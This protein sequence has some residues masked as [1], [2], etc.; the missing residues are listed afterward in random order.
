MHAVERRGVEGSNAVVAAEGRVARARQTL[1]TAEQHYQSL[2]KQGVAQNPRDIAAADALRS[3]HWRV[4]DAVH[5]VAVAQKNLSSPAVTAGV[6]KTQNALAKLDATERGFLGTIHQVADTFK[7]V[8]R[9]A[10]DAVFSGMDRAI[11]ALLPSFKLIGPAMAGLGK[12][13]GGSF[14][15]IGRE[16]A[17]PA[18]TRFF[19]AMTHGAAV[20]VR[21]MTPGFLALARIFRDIATASLP[22]LEKGVRAVS[23]WLEKIAGQTGNAG[24]L[25]SIVGGL[26]GQFASWAKFGASVAKL[27]GTIFMGGAQQGKGLVDTL[28]RILDRWTRFLNTPKGQADMR[29]FFKDAVAVTKLLGGSLGTVVGLF[30]RLGVAATRV[31]G[32]L[33]K[34][35]QH[36]AT[37]LAGWG[38]IIGVLLLRFPALRGVFGSVLRGMGLDIGK[39]RLGERLGESIATPLNRLGRLASA[40]FRKFKTWLLGAS[41]KAGAEAGAAEGEAQATAGSGRRLA[42]FFGGKWGVFKR[43]LLG[44]SAVAGAEAGVAQGEAMTGGKGLLSGGVRSRI[45]G[46]GK[47]GALLGAFKGIGRLFGA[48][49]GVTLGA[50]LLKHVQGLTDK[51]NKMASGPATGGHKQSLYDPNPMGHSLGDKLRDGLASLSPFASGGQ[52]PGGYG[53]GDVIPAWLEPGEHVLTK[54]EVHRAGG[55]GAIHALRRALGGGGQSAGPGYAQ[56]GMVTRVDVATGAEAERKRAQRPLA[57]IRDDLASIAQAAAHAGTATHQ[58]LAARLGDARKAVAAQ[59]GRLRKTAGDDF[60]GVRKDAEAKTRRTHDDTDDRWTDLR[61]RLGHTTEKWRTDTLGV[62]DDVRKSAGKT[63]SRLADTVTGNLDDARKGAVRRVTQLRD[64]VTDRLDDARKNAGRKTKQLADTVTGNLEDARRGGSRRAGQLS[65]AVVGSAGD[66]ERGTTRHLTAIRT[67]VADRMEGARRTGAMRGGQLRDAVAG[68]MRSLDTAVFRGMTYV[69]KATNESLKA[70]GAKPVHVS[71]DLP[72]KAGGGWIGRPGE[73]GGDHELALLGRGEAVVNR[74][75]QTHIEQALGLARMMGAT[76]YGS[77]DSLFGGVTTPHYYARGG[78]TGPGHSGA[79]F[80]PVWNQ[81]RAKFGMTNFTGYDGHPRMTAS[82]NVSDH[83]VHEA[84]DLADGR[85]ED[86]PKNA[87]A[88]FWRTKLPQT[89]HQLIYHDKVLAGTSFVGGTVPGHRDHVH[90]GLLPQFAFNQELMARLI[91]R[92]SRG[93]SIKELLAASGAGMA[94]NPLAVDHVDAPKVKGQG[95]LGRLARAALTRTARGANAHIDAQAARFGGGTDSGPY[96]GFKGGGSAAVARALMRTAR[97]MHSPAE[98]TLALFEAGVVESGMRNLN[99]GDRDSRGVLQQRPSQ[100]W[101]TVAEVSNPFYA[102]RKFLGRA[103]PLA[104]GYPTAGRLAQ[105]VQGSAFPA[106]YDAARGSAMNWIAR[107]GGYGGITR[108]LAR[109]GFVGGLRRF[110]SGGRAR[111]HRPSASGT[112]HLVA[113]SAKNVISGRIGTALKGLGGDWGMSAVTDRLGVLDADYARED[114][115]Y[116]VDV[117]VQDFVVPAVLDASGKVTS[118]AHLDAR[119]LGRKAQSL[120]RLVAIRRQMMGVIKDARAAL[121]GT[122]AVLKDAIGKLRAAR[123]HAKSKDRPGYSRLMGRYVADIKG[124]Q[125]ARGALFTMAQDA[126]LDLREVKNERRALLPGA[127]SALDQATAAAGGGVDTGSAADTG[128]AV[129]DTGSVAGDTGGS[130]ADVAAQAQQMFATFTQSRQD[131][132]SQFGSNFTGAGGPGVDPGT[133]AAGARYWGAFGPGV[134]GAA[135]PPA[136]STSAAPSAPQVTNYYAAPPPDPHTHSVL[137]LHELQALGG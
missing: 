81:A 80:T 128:F 83:S 1:A 123:A 60:E 28:T 59:T 75:Q 67:V 72:K 27:V 34:P 14:A 44:A 132:F 68:S 112:G 65:A 58:V 117:G 3:A 42:A 18:W 61:K 78:F 9:P 107:L 41:V 124:V 137:M 126:G 13:V 86:P 2:R 116:S 48:A 73:Q 110:A 22:Y 63:T 94:G 77:L 89:I 136:P 4:A 43:W 129:G 5:Q 29:Q 8:M 50:A 97:E 66:M 57:G 74:H 121:G 30:A 115:A 52:V 11:K 119:A 125:G 98:A 118:E 21:D 19:G 127:Q 69:A 20:L 113:P 79:G 104:G 36:V 31:I 37:K 103:I 88:N 85:M 102:A 134:T 56:G 39:A 130:M 70:F 122:I 108:A 92:A 45:A 76:Q 96:H 62:F 101:G 24:R 109:G 26:V 64:T 84:L 100:G 15:A 99:Y 133:A 51:L 82:G 95:P 12:A 46:L 16:L 47:G 6:G 135:P 23:G 91:S 106:R 93:L 33:P 53:G 131:L 38:A 111:G 40:P 55:H 87:L 114:R 49:M 7:N 35:L 90:L 32:S 120:D 17:N 25:H 105:A 10:T 71:V 54:D